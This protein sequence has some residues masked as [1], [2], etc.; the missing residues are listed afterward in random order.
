[1]ITTVLI[2]LVMFIAVLWGFGLGLLSVKSSRDDVKYIVMAYI[3]GALTTSIY[4][5]MVTR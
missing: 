4:M 5:A 2:I 1:M 3:S